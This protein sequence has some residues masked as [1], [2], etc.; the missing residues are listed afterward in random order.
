FTSSRVP[1][2]T[3]TWIVTLSFTVVPDGGLE[4]ATS[5]VGP[6]VGVGDSDGVSEGVALGVVSESPGSV[7]IQPDIAS[8][9]DV[10]PTTQGR[11]H[12]FYGVINAREWSQCR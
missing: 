8:S 9:R 12:Q 11:I 7:S 10:R 2:L 4:I 1:S 3:T 6:G 5:G